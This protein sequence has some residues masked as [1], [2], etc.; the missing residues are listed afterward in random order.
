MGTST[1][2]HFC[3]PPELVKKCLNCQRA[4]CNNCVRNI[5][6]TD[7]RRARSQMER[8]KQAEREAKRRG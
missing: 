6:T 4:V 3:D 2:E 1:Y 5:P 8:A 7:M